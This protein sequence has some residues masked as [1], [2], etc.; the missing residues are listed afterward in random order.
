MVPQKLSIPSSDVGK[1]FYLEIDGAMS[2]AM[3]WLNGRLWEV[4]HM[5]T[6]LCFDLAPYIKTGGDNQLAIR[7]DS[8]QFCRVGIGAGLTGMFGCL[9]KS[10]SLI[11]MGHIHPHKKCVSLLGNS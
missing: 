6:I 7:G 11:A 5:V 9:G 2:Y 10:C 8:P 3:V 1:S 4:G